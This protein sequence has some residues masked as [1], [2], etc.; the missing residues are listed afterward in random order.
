MGSGQISIQVQKSDNQIQFQGDVKMKAMGGLVTLLDLKI[1][2]IWNYLGSCM[3]FIESVEENKKNKTIK[4]ICSLSSTEIQCSKLQGGNEFVKQ[5]SLPIGV[6]TENL[7]DVVSVF[8]LPRGNV[9][10]SPVCIIIGKDP[11]VFESHK[12]DDEIHLFQKFGKTNIQKHLVPLGTKEGW[13]ENLQLKLP[14]G[15]VDLFSI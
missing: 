4:K 11:Y 5:V 8:A 7:V 13:I 2:S 3:S 14:I 12:R 1:T 9:D 10:Q 15:K 6:A